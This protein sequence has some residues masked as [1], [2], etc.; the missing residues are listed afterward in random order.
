MPTVGVREWRNKLSRYLQQVKAGEHVVVTERGQAVANDPDRD[1]LALLLQQK[2]VSWRGG[3]PVGLRHPPRVRPVS[4]PTS[5]ARSSR[6]ST[7]TGI[8]MW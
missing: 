7:A 4:S 6:V 8:I 3:K 2:S 1:A 5:L